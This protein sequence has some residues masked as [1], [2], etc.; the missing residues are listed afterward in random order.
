MLNDA[1]ITLRAHSKVF[2]Q[3]KGTEMVGSKTTY[4]T[5][6]VS[7]QLAPN[8][9][10]SLMAAQLDVEAYRDDNFD[11]RICADGV[12]LWDYQPNSKTYRPLRY[13]VESG[14]QAP[15]YVDSLLRKFDSVADVYET[16]IA[17]LLR[18]VY[19]GGQSNYESW[20]PS[21][22]P[23]L[24]GGNLLYIEGTPI[25]RSAVFSLGSD[26]NGNL[27]LVSLDYYED[28]K[29]G[30][31]LKRRTWHLTV[32]KDLDFY[33]NTFKFAPPIGTR[34]ISN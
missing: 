7:F 26:L 8:P 15:E 20:V 28:A 33:P 10:G 1:F 24:V 21:V 4:I 22:A 14:Q 19:G 27:G 13:G 34:P 11:H 18:Q 5:Y 12:T 29:P 16:R 3:L 25:Y 17:N 6:N 32:S 9:D 23:T 31:S 2:F 30:V